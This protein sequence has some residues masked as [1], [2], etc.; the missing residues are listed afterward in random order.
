MQRIGDLDQPAKILGKST[1]DSVARTPK[2]ICDGY[3]ELPTIVGRIDQKQE[4]DMAK[5]CVQGVQAP[6]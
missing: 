1:I 5:M 6:F 2:N 3:V 4:S